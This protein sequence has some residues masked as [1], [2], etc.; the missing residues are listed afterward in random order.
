M[1]AIVIGRVKSSKGKS[2]EVKYDKSSKDVYVSW[3]G[4]S[5]VGKAASANEAMIK[6]EAF[7][8]NK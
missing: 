6:A 1:S 2:Y 4:W 3:A 7:L 8:Y 5:Y